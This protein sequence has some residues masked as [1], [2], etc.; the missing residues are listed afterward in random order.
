MMQ[1]SITARHTEIDDAIKNYVM[2]KLSK[3][4][5]YTSKIVDI[6]V[7]FDIQGFR[8]IAEIILTMKGRNMVVEEEAGGLNEAFDV[9]LDKMQKRVR[10]YWGKKKDHNK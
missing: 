4:Q 3:L 7:I 2:E 8:H 10:R 5:K 6:K 9:A 1:V